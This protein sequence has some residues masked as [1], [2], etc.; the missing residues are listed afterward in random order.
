MQAPGTHT[1]QFA[2]REDDLKLDKVVVTSDPA[3]VPTGAGP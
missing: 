2:Y 3:L 1:L